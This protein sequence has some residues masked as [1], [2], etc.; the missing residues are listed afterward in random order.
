[1]TNYFVSP[2]ST[3]N[4]GD[5]HWMQTTA[6]LNPDNLVASFVE[7]MTCTNKVAGFTGGVQLLYYD[8]NGSGI[9][10]SRTQQN[11]IGQ[12]PLFSAGHRVI[13]GTA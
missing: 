13:I 3:A 1:M 6:E 5:G 4:L 10:N 12:A 8:S 7:T 9:G 11:G 2:V